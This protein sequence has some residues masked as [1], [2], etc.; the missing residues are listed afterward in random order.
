MI[1]ANGL[2]LDET[3]MLQKWL[4][5]HWHLAWHIMAYAYQTSPMEPPGKAITHGPAIIINAWTRPRKA[6]HFALGRVISWWAENPKIIVGLCQVF[7]GKG[8]WYTDFDFFFFKTHVCDCVSSIRKWNLNQIIE[9][10]YGTLVTCL[11]D[12]RFYKF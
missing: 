7:M 5:S 10:S 8:S 4:L 12:D 6:N 1:M 9:T 3:V 11:L 2:V